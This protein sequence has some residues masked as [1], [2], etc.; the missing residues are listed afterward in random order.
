MGCDYYIIKLLVIRFDDGTT[1]YVE[2]ERERG[3]YGWDYDEDEPDYQEKVA[4]YKERILTPRMEPFAIYE[5]NR[6]SNSILESK[7]KLSVEDELKEQDKPWS[8]II[9]IVKQEQ[10]FERE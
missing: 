7:Y 4:A 10:R 6:F 3:Y 5:N 8:S 2:L 1:S 9:D